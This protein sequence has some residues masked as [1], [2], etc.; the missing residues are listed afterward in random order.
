[1]VNKKS[2]LDVDLTGKRILLRVDY[3]VPIEDGK[4][5]SD[6]AWRIDAT[7][8]TLQHLL[9]KNCR[10]VVMA[11]LGRPNGE[12]VES[13]RIRP[14]VDYLISRLPDVPIEVAPGVVGPDVEAMAQE[15]PERSILVLENV[16][17]H[18]GE[19]RNDESFS[20]QLAALA[21][22]FVM[23]GFA[24][25]HRA[26]AST[27]GVAAFLPCVAGLLMKKEIEGLS[28][29][30]MGFTRPVLGVLSG[31]KLET[32]L[33]LIRLFC[34]R[35][36]FVVV[37]G[38]IANTLYQAKGLNV[39]KSLVDE[40]LLGDAK[41]IVEEYGEKFK[42]SPDVMT[43]KEVREG[44]QAIPK[45]VERL[46]DDDIILDMG[47]RGLRMLED[48]TTKVQTVV[49]NGPLGK[50]ETPPFNAGTD[51]FA[52][53]LAEGGEMTTVVGGGDT[54]TAVVR[55]GHLEKFS[56]ISTGGGAMLEYLEGKALP[57]VEVIAEK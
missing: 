5:T 23:D 13:L 29:V 35:Y 57:G 16:R 49:W 39:G 8:P 56:L 44:V 46:D 36:D 51:A 33:G 47:P 38:G 28:R 4:V 37:G 7:L 20:K 19:M 54:V 53:T 50:Y 42:L 48:L 17:F 40:A 32:K 52:H 55:A 26:H 27:V 12:V 34:D 22:F 6:E 24:V 2:I 41:R 11:H 43:A 15:M 14:V 45:D 25:A 3:N 21:D 1:M 9:S 30:M 31:L 18:N 10:V